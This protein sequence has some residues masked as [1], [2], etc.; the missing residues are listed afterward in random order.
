MNHHFWHR[1]LSLPLLCSALLFSAI[2]YW[3]LDF[4]LANRIYALEGGQWLYKDHWLFSTVLHTDARNVMI[5]LLFIVLIGLVSSFCIRQL[6]PLR[7]ALAYLFS[8][9][10]LSALLIT[11]AKH[12]SQMD[13]PW[14]LVNYGGTLA[15]IPYFHARPEWMPNAQCFPAGHASAG[16]AWLGLYFLALTYRPQWK[17][18][19]LVAILCLGILFGAVQQLRGAH[20]ISHDLVT[21]TLCWLTALLLYPLFFSGKVKALVHPFLTQKPLQHS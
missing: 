9:A 19:I 7:T 6:L 11:T 14:D 21:L 16:Y 2:E 5:S 1:H 20:F 8:S 18:L 12:F 3:Q 4:L 13:C 15:F 10:T 17:H